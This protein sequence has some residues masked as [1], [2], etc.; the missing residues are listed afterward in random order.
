MS[1]ASRS[2]AIVTGGGRGLGRA[3]ASA[4]LE[5]GFEVH[6]CGRR[7]PDT[8]PHGGERTAVRAFVDGV[9]QR[10]GR[11]DLVV[12]NAGGSP[13]AQAATASPRFSEAIVALNLL[14]PL[15]LS[16]AAQPWMAAQPQGGAIINIA[17]VSG[18]RPSPGT[19]IYGAAKAGLV[20]LTQSLAQEWAPKIRVNALVL[21][22]MQT[23]DGEG[24]Y[25]SPATQAAIA[26]TI[27][28]QR[29]GGG[30]DVAAA[31]RF[32]ASPA[33]AWISGAALAVDGGGE[34]PLFLDL[35]ARA[36]A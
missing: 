20:S 26:Q 35:V 9:A 32:L 16:Q 36:S 17:S 33:A 4:L 22:L 3:I 24:T 29:F 7:H 19:A 2:T 21:G 1:E 34:R 27:P 18:Q 23:E 15:H 30:E 25:G 6:I 31:V 8:L 14:A 12:N 11:L 10:H 13:Q 28:L 5:D